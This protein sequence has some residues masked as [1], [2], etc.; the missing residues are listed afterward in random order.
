MI[1]LVNS[2][3]IIIEKR[4]LA[5]NSRDRNYIY[6]N[7][8]H[9]HIIHVCYT[10][11]YHRTVRW[12]LYLSKSALK[13]V[14][15]WRISLWQHIYCLTLVGGNKGFLKLL[16]LSRSALKRACK[17]RISLWQ[18]IYCL[19]LVCGN[20]GFLKLFWI[21]MHTRVARQRQS[22]KLSSGTLPIY[23]NYAVNNRFKNAL[24]QANV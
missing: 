8:W 5:D 20:K 14:C 19:T 16:Y 21:C 23:S 4:F 15:K 18:H 3:L 6:L 13:R 2:R 11:R 22:V 24:R 9:I 7:Q 12:I 1:K 17:W 10:Q